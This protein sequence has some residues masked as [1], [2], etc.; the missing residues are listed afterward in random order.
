LGSES[1]VLWNEVG[2]GDAYAHSRAVEDNGDLTMM[3]TEA[4]FAHVHEA[5][6]DIIYTNGMS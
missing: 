2:R 5:I 6:Q 1:E 4:L 3:R